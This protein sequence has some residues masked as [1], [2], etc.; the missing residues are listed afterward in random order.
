MCSLMT[1]EDQTSFPVHYTGKRQCTFTVVNMHVMYSSI[2]YSVFCI[3]HWSGILHFAILSGGQLNFVCCLVNFDCLQLYV[4]HCEWVV[5]LCNVSCYCCGSC[6]RS[7][8]Y[9]ETFQDQSN[10][11]PRGFQINPFYYTSSVN[12]KIVSWNI[13]IQLM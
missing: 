1:L 9:G 10:K 2:T 3:N 13:C 5:L 7:T 6:C 11:F 8:D 4:L 12:N